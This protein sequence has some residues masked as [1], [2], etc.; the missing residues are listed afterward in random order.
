M[1]EQEI[2]SK[3]EGILKNPLGEAWIP[4]NKEIKSDTEFRHDLGMDSLDV[5]EFVYDVEEEFGISIPDEKANDFE[6]I[7]DCVEFIKKYPTNN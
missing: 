3:L 2:F 5:Y 7:K 1:K 4:E 6:T